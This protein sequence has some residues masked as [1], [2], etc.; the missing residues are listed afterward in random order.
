MLILQKC[1]NFIKNKVKTEQYFI[2]IKTG[3]T[4]TYISAIYFN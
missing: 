2:L 3:T 1:S 4:H